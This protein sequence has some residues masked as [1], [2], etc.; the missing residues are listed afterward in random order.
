MD[1]PKA[2]ED[3]EAWQKA[4]ALTNL[5]YQLCRESDSLKRDFGLCDQIRRAALSVM[6]NI[7]EGWESLH[8]AEKRQFYNCARRSCGEVRSMTYVLEDNQLVGQSDIERLRCDC[9]STGKLISG[10]IRSVTK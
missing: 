2:F 6:N 4:R 5:V 10:L 3:L 1:R 8:Q 7:A 9:I